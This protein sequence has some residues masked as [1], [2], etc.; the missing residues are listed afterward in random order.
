MSAF[1][2]P[3]H[4]WLFKKIKIFENIEKDISYSLQEEYPE[5]EKNI[6]QI[7]DVYGTPTSDSPLEEQIDTGN[8]HG[9]LQSQITKAELRQAALITLAID[10]YGDKAK[11]VIQECYEDSGSY[12]GEEAKSRL[13]DVNA[14]ALYKIINDYILEGMPCDNIGAVTKSAPDLTEWKQ[15]GCLHREYWEETEG[16]IDVFYEL[17]KLWVDAFIE[18][19]TEEFKYSYVKEGH[20]Y[21]HKIAKQ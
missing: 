8:I 16:N 14:S 2:G 11:E 15:E 18:S 20:R 13:Q 7:V 4:H 1:L 9:W 5:I 21:F 19:I 10:K 6:Y 3:I 17:R 12:W